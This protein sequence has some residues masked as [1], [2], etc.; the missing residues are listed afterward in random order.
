MPIFLN[1]CPCETRALGHHE[2]GLA[3]T[4]E[5]R[6]DREHEHMGVGDS[7]VGDPRFGPVQHPF[8]LGFVVDR[9]R[10]QR[11]HVGSGVGL[12]HTEGGQ[13]HVIRRSEALGI[14]SPICSGV[15]LAKIP[16]TAKSTRKWPGRC[17]HRPSSSP[18]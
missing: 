11:G 14:H 7:A 18:R 1:F 16:A 13:L 3:A 9:P 10:L 8:V 17:R 6:L 5:R 4:P 12:G 2:G 15:P